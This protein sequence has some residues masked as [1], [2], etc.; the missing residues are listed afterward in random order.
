MTI[1]RTS[2]MKQYFAKHSL[3]KFYKIKTWIYC[4][5]LPLVL[6]FPISS[7]AKNINED[8]NP[9]T[10]QEK[11]LFKPMHADRLPM[12]R[13][14]QKNVLYAEELI[15]NGLLQSAIDHLNEALF[16]Y[17]KDNDIKSIKQINLSLARI[18]KNN[19][20]REKSI[21]HYEKYF[22]SQKGIKNDFEEDLIIF[23]ESLEIFNKK[24]SKAECGYIQKLTQICHPDFYSN[25][26]EYFAVKM[27][28][29]QIRHKNFE[30][31]YINLLKATSTNNQKIM[32][33]AQK[34]INALPNKEDLKKRINI[35]SHLKK[36][37][38]VKILSI[39]ALILI[40]IFCCGYFVIKKM[41]IKRKVNL[42]TKYYHWDLFE[43]SA[44]QFDKVLRISANHSYSKS[45]LEKI[46]ANNDIKLEQMTHKMATPLFEKIVSW[47]PFHY[48]ASWVI[49]CQIFFLTTFLILR[50]YEGHVQFIFFIV[51]GTIG[52]FCC[53]AG[54]IW[55]S[56][57]LEKSKIK[58]SRIIDL[59]QNSIDEWY[60]THINIL[61]KNNWLCVLG[62]ALVSITLL[63][64]I[65]YVGGI[66]PSTTPGKIVL[67]IFV[68]IS[69]FTVGFTITSIFP[70]TFMIYELAD[71]PLITDNKSND[72]KHIGEISYKFTLVGVAIYTSYLLGCLYGLPIVLEIQLVELVM[73]PI[74]VVFFILPQ[75]RIHNI[76]VANKDIQKMNIEK[77]IKK[78]RAEFDTSPDE[79]TAH[80]LRGMRERYIEIQENPEW[81]FNTQAIVSVLS[82]VVI[83]LV[84]LLIEMIFNK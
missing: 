37:T 72:I 17:K 20:N 2:K 54:L 58:I 41:E 49:I 82:S 34:L 26:S 30:E 57:I 67:S 13:E 33:T 16:C 60:Q 68:L 59:D 24:D 53:A 76:M 42:G 4:I 18:Q 73:L 77:Q 70:Y 64:I 31:A 11:S 74:L 40:L 71:L 39:L 5:L 32:S 8:Q 27:A 78:L 43:K 19:N 3:F 1:V 45:M 15:Q 52:I 48:I 23:D 22:S 66:W 25:N 69:T 75:I 51:F 55:A 7:V 62:G 36:R 47:L 56:K 14:V 61:F 29:C 38:S 46:T 44:E 28:D 65:V 9:E 50:Y 84:F 81:S 21:I 6:I 79:N 83:P 80:L 10:K 12:G 63:S 35:N